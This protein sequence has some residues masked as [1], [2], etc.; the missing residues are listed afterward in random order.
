MA[1]IP[2]IWILPDVL[3]SDLEFLTLTETE[4]RERFDHV[5]DAAKSGDLDY[6]RSIPWV[7]F[8]NPNDPTEGGVH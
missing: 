4:Q 5:R 3:F 7:S 6:L 2:Q 1:G 8:L